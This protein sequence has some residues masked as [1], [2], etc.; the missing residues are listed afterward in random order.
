MAKKR[1]KSNMRKTVQD[2][3]LEVID[4]TE[5]EPEVDIDSIPEVTVDESELSFPVEEP[6]VQ[7]PVEAVPEIDISTIPEVTV[8]ASE[9]LEEGPEIQFNFVRRV[10]KKKNRFD[11]KFIGII[12]AAAVVVLVIAGVVG[13]NIYESSVVYKTVR[14]EAGI[15]VGVA[16][17]LKSEDPKAVFAKGSDKI[18]P[19]VPGEYHLKIKKGAFTHNCTLHI[20][21]TT[22]PVVEV[23]PLVIKYGDTCTAEDFVKKLEDATAT[24]VAFKTEPD[25]K[26][27][28]GQAVQIVVTDAGKNT[29]TMNT[30]LAVSPV[31]PSLSIEMGEDIPD[32]SEFVL[33]DATAKWVD[34][35]QT[36][37]DFSIPAT[38]KLD[39]ELNGS[40]YTVELVVLDTIAPVL[41]VKDVKGFLSIERKAEEFVKN[42]KDVTVV[43]YTFETAPDLTKLGTQQVVIIATDQGGNQTK[44]TANLTLE[45]DT[46]APKITGAKNK[47]IYIGE[48]VSYRSGVTITDNSGAECE[49]TVDSTA[50]NNNKVGKYKVVYTAKDPAGNTTSATIT[51]TVIARTYS[52][53]AVNQLADDALATIIKTGMTNR[54]KAQAIYKYI[55]SHV[56]YIS[57][58]EKG[59]YIRAAYEGLATGKG[60]C[61]VYASVAKVMLTRAGITNMD[62][63]RIPEGDSMHYW[64]LVDIGDG[65]GWYHF[66]TTPRK[67][68]TKFFLWD[69][70][71][72]K[73]YSDAHNNCHNYDRS[74]YPDIP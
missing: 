45:A 33:I 41:E 73:A 26:K 65:H 18:D 59:D 57:F 38:H 63:E 35:E 28:D 20:Q 22:A 8:D 40:R 17:F 67:D 53:E 12:A 55:Q 42:C 56:G 15:E 68:K 25:F 49:L 3:D 61:Y 72:I 32:V 50:V 48:A 60:D 36:E 64:N 6:I 74:L 54:E 47:T 24:T 30:Q 44:K 9:A 23:Q 29:V 4:L 51:L 46:V 71:S 69:D 13:F 70:A 52:L 34:K 27:L 58:S 31:I 37:I 11:K 16:D 39:L 14:V 19:A 66:D 7:K 10:P 43:E 2:F 5:E 1:N 62:I 21:D